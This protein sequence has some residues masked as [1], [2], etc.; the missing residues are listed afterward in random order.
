MPVGYRRANTATP[1][2]PQANCYAERWIGSAR[3]E[4]LDQLLILGERHL[5]RVLTAYADFYNQRRP[6]QRLSQ[7]CP[8]PLAL[9]PGQ[10]PIVRHD[11]RGGIIHD[12]EHQKIA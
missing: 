3:R 9:G 6:H 5:Q 7:R 1:H 11:V 8:L 4:C 2:R 12:Y 10:G